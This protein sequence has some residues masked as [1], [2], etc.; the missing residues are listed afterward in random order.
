MFI[1]SFYIFMIGY[2]ALFMTIAPVGYTEFT[3]P[4]WYLFVVL[5]ILLAIIVSFI[6]ELI[7]MNILG[8]IRKHKS[9][10]NT[11]NHYFGNEILRLAQHLMRVKVIVSGKENIPQKDH[12]FIM[13][14]NHQENYDIIIVKP[15]FKDHALSFIAKESLRTLPIFGRWINSL[16]GVFISKDADRSAAESI[17]QAIRNYKTGMCMGIFPEGRR[18]FGNEMIEFKSGAFKLAMKPKADIVIATQ[19]NTC[20]IF[21]KIPWRRYRVYVHI[22]PLL[23]YEDYK[24]MN[25]HELSD[26]VKAKIQVQLDLFKEQIG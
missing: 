10:N 23:K 20:T 3:N 2:I 4:L 25:S 19:Y 5:S 11:L 14:G 17:I 26:F 21:K 16:G 13:V 12:H 1:T 7:V 6:T 22:H 24:D 15:I 8:H 18:A 9:P